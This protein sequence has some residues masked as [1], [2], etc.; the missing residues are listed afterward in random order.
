MPIG[1]CSS[2][3][4]YSRAVAAPKS[5]AQIRLLLVEDMHQVA[6]YIRNL[7]SAQKQVELL[8]V[9]T[10][11]RQVMEQIQEL[12]PDV[13][14]VDALLQ[15]RLDGL[16][17]ARQVRSAGLTLPIIALTVPGRQIAVGEGMGVLR[18]LSMPFSGFD[19]MHLVQEIHAEHRSLAPGSISRVFTVYGAKGGVGTTTLAYNIAVSL[20]RQ[21]GFRVALFDGSLQ[22]GDLRALLH[23]PEDAPSIL[24]L[25]TSHI[26]MGDVTEVMWRDPSGVDVLLA[27]PRIEMAEMVNA[28]DVEKLLSLLRQIYN[29]VLID[30][31]SGIDD[32]LL[33]Y[34]DASDQIIQVLTYES[35][36]LQQSRQVTATLQAI[37]YGPEKLGYVVNRADS[38]GGLEP[39]VIARQIGREPDY[40]VVSDGRLVV[41]ANNRG[42]PFVMTSPDAPISQDIARLAAKL[43]QAMSAPAKSPAARA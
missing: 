8:D 24:Q 19:F 2:A 35:A 39:G 15:G 12:R 34:F 3:A 4:C 26:Q 36:A 20:A 9:I 23:I 33:A 30:T 42:E 29:V 18:V 16:A 7:L 10:D 31:S 27:P 38:T 1:S 14:I 40:R 22:F 17:V 25:P 32:M 5:S 13:L 21:G 43:A 28:R 6:Q 41:E 11:G 37:G